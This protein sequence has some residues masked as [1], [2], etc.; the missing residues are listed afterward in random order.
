MTTDESAIQV[1]SIPALPKNITRRIRFGLFVT[2]L[3]LFIFLVGARPA[4]FGW[5]RSI[6]VGFIQIAVFLVGLALISLGGYISLIAF[7]NNHD[8]TIAADIGMRLVS[9]GYVIAVFSGM[10]DVFGMG[11]QTLPEVPFF[12]NLQSLGVQVGEAIIAIGFLL[13]IPYQRFLTKDPTSTTTSTT[14]STSSSPSS[15]L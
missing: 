11:T 7:W 6:V 9:T 14:T 13:L 5:D 1:L 2:L 12:G 8:R 15:T 4:W 10:A 3:G